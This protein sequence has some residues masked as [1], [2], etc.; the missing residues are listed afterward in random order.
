MKR[1]FLLFVMLSCFAVT[2]SMVL[3]EVLTVECTAHDLGVLV[4]I[5][6]GGAENSLSGLR[7]SWQKTG[8]ARRDD[9]TLPRGQFEVL[10]PVE[11]GEA[12]NLE[13][14][15][16]GT[17]NTGKLSIA[18]GTG[19]LVGPTVELDTRITA[20]VT[21]KGRDYCVISN[22]NITGAMPTLIRIYERE[23]VKL[24]GSF[25]S[26]ITSH[27][28]EGLA[29]GNRYL[30]SLVPIKDEGEGEK[31][32]RRFDLQPFATGVEKEWKLVNR[33]NRLNG[34]SRLAETSWLRK[35]TYSF[36]DDEGNFVFTFPTDDL[37][38]GMGRFNTKRKMW[39][40][41]GISGWTEDHTVPV[42]SA[43]DGLFSFKSLKFINGDKGSPIRAIADCS[44]SSSNMVL[45]IHGNLHEMVFR[46]DD[47]V[48]WKGGRE[49]GK[50][51]S[52]P[53]FNSWGGTGAGWD[54]SQDGTGRG[55][56]I[57]THFTL[58]SKKHLIA[59]LYSPTEKE[60][61][62]KLWGKDG[63]TEHKDY[64]HEFFLGSKS[65]SD[66]CEYPRV[67]FLDKDKWLI[68][69]RYT[70]S[71]K[72]PIW[73]GAEFDYAKN[74]LLRFT[75]K[76][77]SADGE[78]A[79]LFNANINHYT[80]SLNRDNKGQIVLFAESGS[81]LVRMNLDSKKMRFDEAAP[82]A[83]VKSAIQ[84]I[85][86][87]F[88]S[89]NPDSGFFTVTSRAG[90]DVFV[91]GVGAIYAADSPITIMGVGW[92][93]KSPI[94]FIEQNGNLHALRE[95]TISGE[96]GSKDPAAMAEFTD[97][98]ADPNK[99]EYISEWQNYARDPATNTGASY[100][101]SPSG[102]MAVTPEGL[103]ISPHFHVCSA[104]IFH[105]ADENLPPVFWGG[106]WDYLYFPMAA[107]VDRV[108]NKAYISDYLTTGGG[109]GILGGRISA[110]DIELTKRCVYKKAGLNKPSVD[111]KYAPVYT[112][113][114][115]WPSDIAIDENEGLM[116]VTESL[117]SKISVWNITGEKP[118]RKGDIG[119]GILNFP[120]AVSL[121]PDGYV[122]VLDGNLHSVVVLTRDGK[123]VRKWGGAGRAEGQFLYPW[124]MAIDTGTMLIFI[125]DRINR[126]I[127][128]FTPEGR[129]VYSWTS[130]PQATEQQPFTSM[131]PP[132]NLNADATGIGIDAAGYLYVGVSNR[133]V[134]YRLKLKK[135]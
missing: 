68:V 135:P 46:K 31:R 27:K 121:A 16:M 91:D 82:I 77:W 22:I 49:Y 12:E 20:E 94:V 118:V 67:A 35:P 38:W 61:S 114:F 7:V 71:G 79:P 127:S 70:K 39:E 15:A 101:A 125:T 117:S 132:S 66:D 92:L 51:K 73:T 131:R 30:L 55:L 62:W 124:D 17:I 19:R 110:W 111:E 100:G 75:E 129:H 59:N 76:G 41:L 113:G 28:L 40:V 122:Y 103:V 43:F 84:Y 119:I 97:I 107:A 95:S 128:V 98:P 72:S 96:L 106:F 34:D 45:D 25:P 133:I 123:L 58:G 13:V 74:A 29:A 50:D 8:M 14:S 56:L 78:F 134:K 63:W 21:E 93:G 36:S 90:F 109:G 10:L 69:F 54:F 102:R 26:S 32:A 48:Q 89:P 99:V 5:D 87:W 9:V 4:R 23:S 33:G 57:M 64:S 81:N 1:L 37:G 112:S 130:F 6:A 126:R 60:G 47:M 24:L 115:M 65:D 2:G 85:P 105:P 108:R 52:R 88:A 80:Y 120:R 86:S 44:T 3:A 18:Q 83:Q 42:K 104:T 116:F 53:L 11:L